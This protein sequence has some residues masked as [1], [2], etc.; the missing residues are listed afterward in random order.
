M[1]RLSSAVICITDN[2]K[3]FL[4]KENLKCRFFVIPNFCET[5]AEKPVNLE[6]H[7]EMIKIIYCGKF[8]ES[9]GILDLINAFQKATFETHTVLHLFG[10]GILPKINNK[11]IEV[12][13]WVEHDEYIK[14]I[15]NYDF[16]VLPSKQETFGLAFVEA[17]GFGLPVIGT[18]GPAIPE[19][20]K[21]DET[22]ILIE[23]GNVE[24]LT[25]ALEKLANNRKLRVNLGKNAWEDVKERFTPEIV[26][27][28]L[29]DMYSK[30]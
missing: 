8:I 29:E 11:N 14:N 12:K 2:M 15:Q 25:C 27:E 22:G 6:R 28:K 18:F 21:N 7:K 10:N 26:L 17:M 19:I 9:K 30:I 5:I 20:V 3:N 23:F 1:I 24:Q 16:L 4:E 13:G